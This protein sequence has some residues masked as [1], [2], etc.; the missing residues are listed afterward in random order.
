MFLAYLI[1]AVVALGVVI[2]P[3][4]LLGCVSV[5]VSG[6]LPRGARIGLLTALAACSAPLWL[7]WEAVSVVGRPIAVI[8]FTATL[9]SGFLFLGL[10][11]ER[12]WALGVPTPMWPGTPPA[13]PR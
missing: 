6:R 8:S 12:R 5:L 4:A 3:G 2:V 10:E 11:R 9:V 1:Y 7:L 13:D